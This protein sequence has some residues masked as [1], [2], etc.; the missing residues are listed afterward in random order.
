MIPYFKSVKNDN[1][2]VYSVDMIKI[3]GNLTTNN[4]R[5]LEEY[6]SRK[7]ELMGW[8][9]PK[10]NTCPLRYH[11]MM[12]L[13]YDT[14]I[15][16]NTKSSIQLFIGLNDFNGRINNDII[17]VFNP[18]KVCDNR[19][20]GN[21]VE[22]LKD[23]AFFM[24]HISNACVV[25]FDLAIDI[26]THRQNV[27][28]QACFGR[29]YSRVNGD[30]TIITE[31][32]IAIVNAEDFT[33]YVGKHQSHGFLKIYNKRIESNLDYDCT[34]V[35][36]TII[37]SDHK[38]DYRYSPVLYKLNDYDVGCNEITDNEL[39][40]NFYR[41]ACRL[42]VQNEIL[43]M[44]TSRKIKAK[45]KDVMLNQYQVLDWVHSKEFNSIYA[46]LYSY[47]V[48]E[49]YLK[50][51]KGKY[52]DFEVYYRL[53]KRKQYLKKH[54][55]RDGRKWVPI[56]DLCYEDILNLSDN[57]FNKA[58]KYGYQIY[59]LD[60]S[61]VCPFKFVSSK[62]TVETG[63]VSDYGF[64][65]QDTAYRNAY[66]SYIFSS[67]IIDDYVVNMFMSTFGTIYNQYYRYLD[68]QD[69]Y[70]ISVQFHQY[71]LTNDIYKKDNGD[72]A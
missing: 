64:D 27:T 5:T 26:P 34:R 13:I 40:Q 37:C 53:L 3:K 32:G 2:I 16:F 17:L 10:I 19:Y 31:T 70:D 60:Y 72:I 71:F 50:D 38:Q 12:Q 29:A 36:Y 23:L 11:Y 28:T 61:V 18:N 69:I 46:N 43:E 56:A 39:Y 57:A 24:K 48:A 14:D 25:Q 7:S 35:E 47:C 67:D 45:L 41:L 20:N 6:L 52:Y 44:F 9:E 33:Q 1:N 54:I 68:N 58:V 30:D 21:A 8:K 42:Q 55:V 63:L 51:K 59:G 22:A 65:I 62:D 66:T 15:H 49:T 4:K